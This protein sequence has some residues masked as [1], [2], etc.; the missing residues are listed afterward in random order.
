MK[1]LLLL[2]F[3]CVLSVNL[4]AQSHETSLG[5]N[6]STM[7]TLPHLTLSKLSKPLPFRMFVMQADTGYREQ[8]G[9]RTHFGPMLIYSRIILLR[10]PRVIVRQKYTRHGSEII[11]WEPPQVIIYPAQIVYE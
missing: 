3:L 7:L 4:F 10:P 1:R 6:D 9:R 11:F 2:T 8:K 5:L